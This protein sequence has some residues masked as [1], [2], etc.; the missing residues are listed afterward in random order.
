MPGA[1]LRMLVEEQAALK[2]VAVTV[3]TEMAAERVFDVVTEEVA[4]LLGADAANLVRF[5]PTLDE[6]VIVGK[7][8]EFGVPIP[9]AGTV[10]EIRG[11]A[12]AEVARTRAPARMALE[13]PDVLPEL[14]ARLVALGVTSVVAAPIVVSGDIWG[15]VVA[16]VT[17]DLQF[18]ANAE[19]RLGKFAGLVAVALANAQA[20]EELATLADEQAALSRVAVAVAT[21]EDPERLF[22]AVSEELG[23]LFGARAAA[24]VRYVGDAGGAEIVGGWERD[25]RLDAAPL[26]PLV[27]VDGGAIARVAQTGRA[28]RIDLENEPPD[29]QK[30]MVEA[31]VSSGVAAPIVVSGLL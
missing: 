30:E 18:A 24:T 10:V 4:R 22:N 17:R 9:G 16:S 26:G 11:G 13:D 29:L 25:G 21:E 15:A 7:W 23:R 27:P 28:A 1:D 6:G 2:R 12:L 20:R 3:A 5:G 8:S 31:G 19:E 14:H